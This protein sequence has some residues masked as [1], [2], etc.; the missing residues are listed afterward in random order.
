MNSNSKTEQ[1]QNAENGASESCAQRP[2][3]STLPLCHTCTFYISGL[4]RKLHIIST[5]FM[6]D[7]VIPILLQNKY[8]GH[9]SHT[10]MCMELHVPVH[11]VELHK[12]IYIKFP[13]ITMWIFQI[14]GLLQTV[15]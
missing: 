6:H 12:N 3:L 15:L 9:I 10:Y 8:L 14:Q 13:K 2:L 11:K 5:V 7:T 4:H 1:Y